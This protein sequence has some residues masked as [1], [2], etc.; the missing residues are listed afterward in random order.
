MGEK[1]LGYYDLARKLETCRVWRSW[2]GDSSYASFV[3]SLDSPSKWEAFMR[4]DDSKS[5]AQI[6]LQL[7]VRALL[8]DKASVSLFLR[9][10]PSSSSSSS[11][12]SS[13]V[14]FSKL[15]PTYLRLHGDDVY[16]TLENSV[17]DGVQHRDGGVSSTSASSK[18]LDSSISL[19]SVSNCFPKFFFFVFNC[20][21][22]NT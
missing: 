12:A 7:R 1:G 3:H 4:V 13:S 6:H 5:R 18:V 22:E 9:S 11:L 20:T 17:Q 14:A 2:L 10:N 15:N 21:G 19:T 16:F 8:F